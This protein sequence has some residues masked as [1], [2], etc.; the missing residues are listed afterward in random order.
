MNV[1]KYTMNNKLSKIKFITDRGAAENR[2]K[3]SRLMTGYQPGVFI[4]QSQLITF[5]LP[6]LNNYVRDTDFPTIRFL[7]SG[8]YPTM[9]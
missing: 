9:P 7:P 6:G 1:Q 8:V 3:N 2:N 5:R 4:Y